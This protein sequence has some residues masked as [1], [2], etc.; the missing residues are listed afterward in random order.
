M[1]PK[2]IREVHEFE[3]NAAERVKIVLE[4]FGKSRFVDFRVYYD[5]S[6]NA[7]PDWKPTR[8]GLCISV[9]L[10]EELKEGLDK[11]TAAL[12]VAGDKN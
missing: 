2:L 10:L 1:Q 3:K 6:D 9:D 11:A 7:V 4:E 5:A 12:E 8:K